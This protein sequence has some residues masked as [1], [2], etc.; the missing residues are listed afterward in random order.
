MRKSPER[1]VYALQAMQLQ[2]QAAVRKLIEAAPGGLGC[3]QL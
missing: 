1:G 2:Q 3:L